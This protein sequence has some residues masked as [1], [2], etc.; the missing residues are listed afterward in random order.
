MPAEHG[1]VMHYCFHCGAQHVTRLGTCRV[2]KE[3]VCER[4]GNTHWVQG[5][6]RV[7]HDACRDKDDDSGFSMIKFVK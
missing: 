5:E 1:D 2:C 4:C 6:R 3:A 7:L